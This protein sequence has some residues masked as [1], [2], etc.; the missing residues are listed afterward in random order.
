MSAGVLP[1]AGL[2]GTARGFFSAAAA[3]ALAGVLAAAVWAAHTE[4]QCEACAVGLFAALHSKP[5]CMKLATMHQLRWQ[6]DGFMALL[7]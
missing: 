3:F 5:Q 4:Y 2:A 7:A 1:V 6:L